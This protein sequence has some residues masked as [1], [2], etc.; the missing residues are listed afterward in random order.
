MHA[1]MLACSRSWC[2]PHAHLQS[3]GTAQVHQCMAVCGSHGIVFLASP[4][5]MCP[6]CM[7]AR[8]DS[9]VEMAKSRVM[10]AATSQVDR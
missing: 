3:G 2:K 4:I 10:D 1:R 6:S 7:Q 5:I 9:A 8:I